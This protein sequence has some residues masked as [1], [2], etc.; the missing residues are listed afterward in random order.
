MPSTGRLGHF[1]LLS[2]AGAYW[3]GDETRP[4]LQRIY[5][6]AWATKKELKTHLQRLAEAEKRD[7]RRLAAELDL[8]SLARGARARAR[9]LAPEGRH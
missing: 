6:T 1:K 3:R 5:G 2:V 9:G 7:H 8:V 4:M